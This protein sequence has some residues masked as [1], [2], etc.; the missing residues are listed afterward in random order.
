MSIT[1]E[2][3]I[4]A[5]EIVAAVGECI[6]GLGEV[7][8]GELYARLMDKFD[9]H[10]YNSIINALKRAKL[11]EEKGFLLTWVGPKKGEA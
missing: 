2:Q 3:T 8:S 5:F 1:K 4:A 6:Q 11:V 10:Q 7:P 9:I